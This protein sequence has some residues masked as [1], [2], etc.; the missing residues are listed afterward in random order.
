MVNRPILDVPG[1]IARI[2]EANHEAEI[3]AWRER[4]RLLDESLTDLHK[5]LES[6][7]A[8]RNVLIAENDSWRERVRKLEAVVQDMAGAMLTLR[9]AA[10]YVLAQH[11]YNSPSLAA[12]G[13][14][15]AREERP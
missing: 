8:D 3:S 10:A 11:G 2:S 7:Q 1:A 4:I 6:T 15:L 9:Q 14:L 13:K 12:L 5:E